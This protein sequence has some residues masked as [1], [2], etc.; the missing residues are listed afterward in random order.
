MKSNKEKLLSN[1][2]NRIT[3]SKF[4]ELEA[5]IK[6]PQVAV[7]LGELQI[8]QLELEMQNDELSM[9]SDM[10]EVERSKF[11][12]FF[13]LAPIGYFILDQIGL[14]LEVNQV[15]LELLAV[16]RKKILNQRFQ[17]F[18]FPDELDRFYDF[19]HQLVPD[20]PKQSIE[21]QIRQL[22]GESIYAKLEGIAIPNSFTNQIS[23][24]VT[25][26]DITSNKLAQRI[27]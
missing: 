3:D 24:Y 7:L 8:A 20:Q 18:I 9:T 10:L 2:K 23:Y 12:G 19:I 26:T 6:D 11:A 13:D 16:A 22:N 21:I 27:L 25:V 5:S 17:S 4:N 1:Y 15:G 14:V